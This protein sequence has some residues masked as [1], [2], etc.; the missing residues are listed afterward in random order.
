MRL[1]SN[2]IADD[3]EL[4]IISGCHDLVCVLE[5]LRVVLLVLRMPLMFVSHCAMCDISLRE[6]LLSELGAWL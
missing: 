5:E 4:V 2:I 1:F 3:V 6:G